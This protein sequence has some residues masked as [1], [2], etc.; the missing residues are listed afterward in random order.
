MGQL[1]Q[2]PPVGGILLGAQAP[3][4]AGQSEPTAESGHAEQLEKFGRSSS[5][6][7]AASSLDESIHMRHPGFT[8][9]IDSFDVQRA[10][11]RA[12]RREGR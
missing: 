12:R 4:A 3:D 2:E 8:L 6:D 7:H 10:G 1:A 9:A 11:V 5:S